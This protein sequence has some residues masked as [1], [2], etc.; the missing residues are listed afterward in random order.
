MMKF[1]YDNPYFGIDLSYYDM[2]IQ[3]KKEEL[4]KLYESSGITKYGVAKYF[5]IIPMDILL[6]ICLMI[7]D[8]ILIGLAVL[9]VSI[10]IVIIAVLSCRY[11]NRKI[12]TLEKE[13]LELQIHKRKEE[14]KIKK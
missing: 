11:R 2:E 10:L 9:S 1:D 8:K 3:R 14:E 7:A 13:I 12:Q 5:I 4:E 6:S